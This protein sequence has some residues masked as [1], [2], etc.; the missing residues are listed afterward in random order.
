MTSRQRVCDTLEHR[1]VDRPPRQ[2]WT[3]PYIPMFRKAELDRMQEEFPSDFARAPF[4][5]GPSFARGTPNLRG[6]YTDAFGCHWTV[7]EDGVAG[8]VKDP[9]I[10]EYE[11]DLDRYRLPWDMLR[12]SDLSGVNDFC[13]STDKFVL[14][15]TSIRPF[16]RMQFLRGTENLLIDIALEEPG[17]FTLRDRLHEF[18][19]A[20]LDRWC[21]TDVDGLS[22]MDDWGSQRSTLISPAAWRKLFKPLYREY[23]EKI[24]A[25]GKFAFFHSDGNIQALYPD[26]VEIGIDAV[27]SQLFCM[28]METL[29]RDF[30]GKITF[31]GE[32]DRQHILPFG[33]P[34]DVAKA[35]ERVARAVR[36]PELCSGVIAQCEWAKVDPYE[37]IAAVFD[38]WNRA[39]DLPPR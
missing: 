3:L 1:S 23:C 37:N 13:R 35:V 31:W 21:A 10:A 28:D 9:V 12:Q 6:S 15:G 24:H 14:Q 30:A 17:F 5:N 20:D 34:E 33:T 18:Y 16:E 27:N 36:A 26:L 19:L 38:A 4:R 11:D 29:G 39:F 25:A 22:F 32:I 2:L 8:E 7:A